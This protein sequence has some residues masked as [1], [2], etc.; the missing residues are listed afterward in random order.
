MF[1]PSNW[2]KIV[3]VSEGLPVAIIRCQDTY[4]FEDIKAAY[5]DTVELEPENVNLVYKAKIIK[6]NESPL[7]LDIQDFYLIEAIQLI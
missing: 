1:L 4:R 5:C 2:M 3:V 6:D 7:C